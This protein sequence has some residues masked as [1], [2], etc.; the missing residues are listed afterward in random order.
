MSKQYRV[1]SDRSVCTHYIHSTRGKRDR[2]IL[3]ATAVRNLRQ[4]RKV[5]RTN[6]NSKACLYCCEHVVSQ[7]LL[8]L[9]QAGLG[10]C[11]F[12]RQTAVP[13]PN[14]VSRGS[15]SRWSTFLIFFALHLELNCRHATMLLLLLLL[16]L[17]LLAP[18]LVSSGLGGSALAPTSVGHTV[19]IDSPCLAIT[20][21][22][23]CTAAGSTECFLGRP[24][25]SRAS[26][27]P[28][29]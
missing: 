23:T 27:A 5:A 13:L 14:G 6:K 17:L 24:F 3:L 29:F 1:D 2:G 18:L 8:V 12:P 26:S 4:T 9:V 10:P 19:S 16:P 15:L 28:L 21:S 11:T 7:N 25:P 22:S 20:L